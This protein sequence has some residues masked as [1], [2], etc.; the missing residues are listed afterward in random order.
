MRRLLAVALATAIVPL[1]TSA[2][3]DVVKIDAGQISGT[4][5]N[6][7]RVFKGIPF[8]APPAGALRWQAPRPV[9]AWTGVRAAEAFGAECMQAPY[10]TTSPYAR[11]NGPTSEDCLYLNVWTTAA[12]AEKRPVMVWIHGGAWTRGTGS[13][14]TYDG[15]TLAKK[16]VVVVTTNYRLGVFGFLAHPELTAESPDHASGNYAILDH[17]A[18]LKWVQ[19]NIAAFGGDPNRVTIFGESDGSWSVNSVQATPLAKGMLHRAIGESGGQ[20]ASTMQHAA[21]ERWGQT[22]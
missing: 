2:A 8:A 22:S 12:A 20:V 21:A 5:D 13:V 14:A 19:K 1:V 6:G 16:G 9:A 4:L 11:Q 3:P 15:A 7:V 10:P 18:A 17:I